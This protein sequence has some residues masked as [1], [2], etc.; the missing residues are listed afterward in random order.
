MVVIVNQEIYYRPGF[1]L[2]Y[3][4]GLKRPS[5]ISFYLLK[6]SKQ[7]S[8]HHVGGERRGR[9]Q[10]RNFKVLVGPAENSSKILG[11]E[12]VLQEHF[13]I[14]L[15]PKKWIQTNEAE[16]ASLRFLPHRETEHSKVIT[17]PGMSQIRHLEQKTW[18]KNNRE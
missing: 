11:N 13:R 12:E 15:L 14:H 2:W 10:M 1:H 18:M 6:W 4:N 9:R 17:S 3:Y 7:K 5:S 8:Q 16:I